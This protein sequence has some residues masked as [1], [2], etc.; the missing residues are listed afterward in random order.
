VHNVFVA[1]DKAFGDGHENPAEWK[2]DR[3]F[4]FSGI[5]PMK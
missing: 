4:F 2:I 1:D 5:V 3:R